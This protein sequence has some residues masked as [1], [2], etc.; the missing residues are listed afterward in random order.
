VQ[1]AKRPHH[2]LSR[3]QGEIAQDGLDVA[4]DL[5]CGEVGELRVPPQGGERGAG[6]DQRREIPW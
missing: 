5:R 1:E 3:H 2:L 4:V 6:K